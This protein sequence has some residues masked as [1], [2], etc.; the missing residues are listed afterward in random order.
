MLLTGLKLYLFC[1]NV[2]NELDNYELDCG[3]DICIDNIY[4]YTNYYT[5][6]YD[7]IGNGSKDGTKW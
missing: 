7:S 6:Y 3:A 2:D 1:V 5:N 4:Y